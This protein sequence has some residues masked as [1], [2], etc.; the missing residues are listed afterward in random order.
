MKDHNYIFN[1]SGLNNPAHIQLQ[2][3]KNG[4]K[5]WRTEKI[6]QE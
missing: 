3:V 5:R 4:A 1:A 6:G 2:D